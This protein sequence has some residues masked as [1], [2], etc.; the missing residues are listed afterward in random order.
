MM[1]FA[2]SILVLFLLLLLCF[3]AEAILNY[4]VHSYSAVSIFLYY[5]LPTLFIVILIFCLRSNKEYKINIAISLASIGI[6]LFVINIFFWVSHNNAPSY[7]E[8]SKK[9]KYPFDSR[10]ILE[11]I[12]SFKKKNVVANPAVFPALFVKQ[13]N[14]EIYPL[15][16]L[17]NSLTV[18]DNESGEY[19]IYYS[20]RYGFHNTGK[21]IWDFGVS[22]IG[23]VGDSFL[24]GSGVPTEKKHYIHN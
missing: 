21:D 18:Y 24:Q 4:S 8:L 1:K 9:K 6:C 10:T 3:L 2:N 14:M 16:G 22:E 17:S 7:E 11:V 23:A 19:T 20:D 12:E 15:S 13:N 5:I